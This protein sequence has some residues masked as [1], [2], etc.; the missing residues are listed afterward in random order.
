MVLS[1]SPS[2]YFINIINAIH[3]SMPPTPPAVEHQPPYPRWHTINGLSP[4]IINTVFNFQENERYNLR[5]GIH[6]AC[7]NIHTA[8][9]GTD[10]ISSLEPK[11]WKPIP[12]KIKHGSIL[13]ALKPRINLGTSTT[14]HADYAKYLLRILVLLKFVRVSYGIHTIAYSFFLKK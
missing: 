4:I 13:S 2:W 10:T 6:L 12:D 3:F 1:S 14:T 8:H 9:F 5:S 7:R 11:L